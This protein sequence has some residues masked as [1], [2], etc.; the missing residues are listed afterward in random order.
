MD[1]SNVKPPAV[2]P[3]GLEFFDMA[4]TLRR[5][6]SHFAFLEAES[7]LEVMHGIHI[8]HQFVYY[9]DTPFPNGHTSFL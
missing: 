9:L 6:Y 2:T 5:T 1:I 7:T 3:K 4:P 8:F